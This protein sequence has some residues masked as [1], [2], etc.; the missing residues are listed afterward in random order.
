MTSRTR[1]TLTSVTARLNLMPIGA[2]L[3]MGAMVPLLAS[4]HSLPAGRQVT[5]PLILRN[6]NSLNSVF[7]S[8]K[9]WLSTIILWVANLFFYNIEKLIYKIYRLIHNYD[10]TKIYFIHKM[11]FCCL[12]NII[13]NLAKKCFNFESNNILK[14]I[15]TPLF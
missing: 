6:V 3:P 14:N 11:T 9:I 10:Y 12:L 5:D 15:D 8:L 1:P 2:V 7:F 4:S 13:K